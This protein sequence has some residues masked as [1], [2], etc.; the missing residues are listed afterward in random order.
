MSRMAIICQDFLVAGRN[1]DYHKKLYRLVRILNRLETEREVS[2]RELAEEFNV[3]MRTAQRDL[4]LINMAEFPLVSMN[5][6]SYAFMPGFSLK[7]LP[8]SGEEASLLAFLCEV[9]E[10]MGG[11][12]KKSFKSLYSK[13]MLSSG[14]DSPF[15]AIFPVRGKQELPAMAGLGSAIE[16]C[17]KVEIQYANGKSHRLRPLKLI[18]F[19]GFWY[20]FAQIDGKRHCAQFR[21]DRITS[22]E[23]LGETF[24]PPKNLGRKLAENRSIWFDEKR[25]KKVLLR[26]SGDAAPYFRAAL[27]FPGQRT[28]RTEKDGALVV[29]TLVSHFMEVI[30]T[31]LKWIPHITVVRPRR[32]KTEI[33]DAVR[34]Y[35][36]AL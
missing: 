14:G 4:E 17:R 7:R 6:G 33:R 5:K 2:P 19:E 22:V 11:G 24:K 28:K 29:E 32:L 27:H 35:V 13:V 36:K 3:S 21:L 1:K 34:E 26:I 15:H 31:I 25:D 23:P 16:E 10:S 18:Q 9:A 30:P 8:L 20:L 12:F